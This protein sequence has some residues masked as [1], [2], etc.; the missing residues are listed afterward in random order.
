MGYYPEEKALRGN[1]RLFDKLVVGN[2]DRYDDFVHLFKKADGAVDKDN[3]QTSL[4]AFKDTTDATPTQPKFYLKN[5]EVAH[6]TGYR[7][8]DD[9]SLITGNG[10]KL[11]IN[12][13]D[14]WYCSF[15]QY[16]TSSDAVS[17]L[18]I[19]PG[20]SAKYRVEFATASVKDNVRVPYGHGEEYN[21]F[22]PLAAD[23]PEYGSGGGTQ[24]LIS[25]TEIPVTAIWDI[26]VQPPVK[27]Y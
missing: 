5:P 6:P 23:Y 19:L 12:T 7:Y 16:S 25:D 10:N 11:P 26:S 4:E 20:N 9:I 2:G 13:G 22:E 15:D 1:I 27:I 24:N 14:G 8:V 17:K 18:E 21:W 3:L